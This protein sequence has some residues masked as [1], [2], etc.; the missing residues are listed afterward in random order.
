MIAVRESS[1]P[2]GKQ[3]Y[4]ELVGLLATRGSTMRWVEVAM[5]ELLMEKEAG[6]WLGLMYAAANLWDELGPRRRRAT[7]WLIQ[8]IAQA[9]RDE[10]KKAIMGAFNNCT[11][12]FSD[13]YTDRL[14]AALLLRPDVL[15]VAV[16]ST[17]VERLETVLSER[18]AQVA[19]LAAGFVGTLLDQRDRNG[20][21]GQRSPREDRWQENA[22]HLRRRCRIY[23]STSRKVS[24]RRRRGFR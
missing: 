20:D 17:F 6:P 11:V 23:L 16:A 24:R 14:C 9:S 13:D 21:R 3:A 12:V 18:P 19:G 22:G 1:W 2:R 10:E 8:G 7:D 4:G 5:A 15:G